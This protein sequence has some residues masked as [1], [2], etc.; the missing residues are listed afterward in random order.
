M[1]SMK[2]IIRFISGFM[3]LRLKTIFG[4]FANENEISGSI[5]EEIC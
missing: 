2:C 5:K 4:C 1:M 3:W